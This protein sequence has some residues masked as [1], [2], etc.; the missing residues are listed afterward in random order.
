MPIRILLFSLILC[1]SG[2]TWAGPGRF[3]LFLKD[4]KTAKS[5]PKR[6]VYVYLPQNYEQN[7][8]Q[9]YPVLYMQDGQNLF[10]P[11]RA[12]LGQT[13]KAETTLN[14]LIAKKLMAPIFLVAID[15]TSRR[16]LEYTHDIDL[17]EGKG[18]EAQGY[19]RMIIKKLKPQIDSALRTKIERSATGIM[20]SSLGGLVSIYA[21]TE[22]SKT[23]GLVGAL[24]PSIWWNNSSIED[25]LIRA[26]D[27]PLKVYLDS[28]DSGGER[29]QDVV[30]LSNVYLQRGLALDKNLKVIIQKGALHT[31]KFWAER[32]PLALQFLYPP[33]R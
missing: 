28:G 18:G 22:F 10:D 13:W 4:F 31:E 20:G 29:P 6:D 33:H 17:R 7:T 23:F 26:S 8:S 9:R 1:F 32:F 19:L 3:V 11:T 5:A 21:G 16:I 15:N 14:A 24:S 25:V 27:L 12:F 30:Q 2:L